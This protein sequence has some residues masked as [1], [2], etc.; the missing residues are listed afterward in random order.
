MGRLFF[1]KFLSL[2][3]NEMVYAVAYNQTPYNKNLWMLL[4]PFF[5]NRLRDVSRCIN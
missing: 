2:G 5:E 4:H 1:P 3:E